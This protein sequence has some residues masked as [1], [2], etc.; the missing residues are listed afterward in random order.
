MF[1]RFRSMP[2]TA[3]AAVLGC[4]LMT[5]AATPAAAR[6]KQKKEETAEGPQASPSKGFLPAVQKMDE[7][8]KKQD[9]AALQAAIAEGQG[10]ATTDDDKYFLGFFT[11]QLGILNKDQALQ[12]QGLDMALDSGK[13]QPANAATFNFFSGQFAYH[14]KEYAKAIQRLE[15]AKAAGSTEPNLPAML[16]ESYVNGGQT[17]KGIAFA[18]AEIDRMM[19]AGQTPPDWM[20]VNPVNALQKANRTNEAFDLLALRARVYPN[21]QV[22]NQALRLVLREAGA[23]KQLSLDV[24]RLMRATGALQ[25]RNEYAE[26]AQL[27]TEAALPGEAVAVI[28]AGQKAGVVSATDSQ[29]SDMKKAQAE[30]AGDEESTIGAYAKKPSTLANPKVAGAT[31]DALFGYGRYAEAIPLYQAAA[32]AGADKDMWTYRLAAAQAMAGDTAA[33]KTGFGQVGGAYALAAKFW[34]AKLN[35]APAGAAPA[36]AAQPAT[37]N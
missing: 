14:K 26:Y 25:N 20:F 15:A 16:L 9:A 19:A 2:A 35:P 31:G 34:L 7:S 36:P 3:M 32:N 28:D 24:F 27:A 11:L 13:V 29:L 21:P 8:L 37:A 1:H 12:E 30:R 5:T 10:T 23:S 17:D 33:A 18:K 4:A 22:W 6:E